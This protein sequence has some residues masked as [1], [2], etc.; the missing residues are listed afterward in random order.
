MTHDGRLRVLLLA[1]HF[2]PVNSAGAQ[3]PFQMMKLL[4]EFGVDVTVITHG[5]ARTDI[6]S[7]PRI[8]RIYDSNSRGWGKLIHYPIRVLQ[9]LSR[10]FG[11][12]T[13]WHGVWAR[14]VK[15]RSAE[16]I[17][18]AHPD[19]V[20]STYPPVETLEL[21]FYFSER[22]SLP[23]V[24][25]FRDGLLFEPV[26]PAMLRSKSTRARYG[27]LERRIARI[28]AGI[29]T[30]SD[31]ITDYFRKEYHRREVITLPNGFDREEDFV[32]PDA[33]AMERGKF[34]LVYTGRLGLS[35]KGRKASAFVEGVTCA[36]QNSAQVADR[37]RIHLVGEFSKEERAALTH[38]IERGIVRLHPFV[39]RRKALGF[40]RAA[41]MLLLVA[42]SG[43]TSV[44]TSKLFEY[45]GA[46][47]PILGVTR[48][49]AAEQIIL[50]TKTGFVVDP[51]DAAAVGRVLTRLIEDP[52]YV[53]SVRRSESEIE[54]FSRAN[55]MRV[56][57][58]FL[59]DVA[60]ARAP[61]RQVV[62][63]V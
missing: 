61:M 46:G 18:I 5:Y 17:R 4:P 43:K 45:L 19:V 41:T 47:R 16:I 36:V 35:E 27:A 28:A 23:L 30:V 6:R 63:S 31:P 54:K 33:D 40:Q 1:Y 53:D 10:I 25:D 2:P 32:L 57:A 15:R 50:Q 3:R 49:T 60:S 11:A 24:A 26:E 59:R 38:L 58:E 34:N 56:L 8:L 21:G 13:S 62:A 14:G 52:G 20:V 51:D 55:Q 42:S 48:N 9:R 44:A 29:V 37:L 39:E 22:Y 7:H 12:S